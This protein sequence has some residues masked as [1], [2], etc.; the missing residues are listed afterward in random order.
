MLSK[1]PRLNLPPHF[2][3]LSSLFSLRFR[4]HMHPPFRDHLT[5][6]D[7]LRPW[8]DPPGFFLP[9]CPCCNCA[10]QMYT[11]GGLTGVSFPAAVATADKS[12]FG[13][14]T[15]AAVSSAN[16]SG[17]RANCGSAANPGTAGYVTG[18]RATLSGSDLATAD[19]TTF[20]ND[21]TSAVPSAN[22]SQAREELCGLSERSTKAYF[23]GGGH[24]VGGT[25]TA[26]TT[27]DKLTFSGESTSAA[28]TANLSAAR[29]FP[30]GMSEGTLKGYWGGG[31]TGAA[32]ATVT[33]V[34][35]LTFSNDTA[36]AQ[37]PAALSVA[38]FGLFAGSD[39][40]TKG[41]WAGGQ[42]GSPLSTIDKTTFSNDTTASIAPTM[43][44]NDGSSGSDANKLVMLG[45]SPPDA[46]GQK[47]TFPS[48]ALAAFG[49]G[50]AGN[51][52]VARQSCCGFSTVGL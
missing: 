40:S 17:N 25:L 39:G 16:L 38:R 30:Q 50:T 41:Y 1:R 28:S 15:T 20:S 12:D 5:P 33:T 48:D 10:A 42:N 7:W 18:G 19:K 37:A 8:R 36:A 9:N 22:L 14:E 35:K 2:S 23:G 13:A 32:T 27:A 29:K 11:L 4:P 46:T 34:E 6:R 26:V 47:L 45:A 49:S 24:D 44:R 31:S 43:T 51:L 21:T 52:S 3:L